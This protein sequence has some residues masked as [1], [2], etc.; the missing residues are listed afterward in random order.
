MFPDIVLLC[1]VEIHFVVSS[2]VDDV[3]TEEAG[4]SD[5]ILLTFLQ[6]ATIT[7]VDTGHTMT[8]WSN[9]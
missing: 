4:L 3:A 9:L 2:M 5:V 6:N 7:L 1:V 8:L